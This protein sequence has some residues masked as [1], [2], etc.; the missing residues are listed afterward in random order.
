MQTG[1]WPE[2]AVDIVG[3]DLCAT[4]AY[5]TRFGGVSIAPVCPFGTFDERAG[6][7]ETSVPM[8]FVD[9]LRRLEDAPQAALGFFSRKHGLSATPGYVLAQGDVTFPDAPP[10]GYLEALHER[11]AEFLGSVPEGGIVR[12]LG[13]DAYYDKRLPVTLNVRRLL[14]WKDPLAAG[15]PNVVGDPLAG[16]PSPQRPPKQGTD[17]LVA[18]RKYVKQLERDDGHVLGF[19]DSEGRPFLVPFTPQVVDHR[20]VIGRDDL[21]RGGRRAAAMGFWCNPQLRGQGVWTVRGWLDVAGSSATFAPSASRKF[22]LSMGAFGQKVLT[23][24]LLGF[25]YRKAVRSG[26]VRDGA[27]VRSG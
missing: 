25:K 17:P 22:N 12:K 26:A 8:M 19:L 11:W 9:K 2:E 13:G 16:P 24:I 21:P 23:P 15:D 6:T 4:F 7:I 14:Y 1:A 18:S 10:A 3:G 27:F 5:T 20:I